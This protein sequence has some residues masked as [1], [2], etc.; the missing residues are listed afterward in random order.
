MP[1]NGTAPPESPAPSSPPIASSSTSA[2]PTARRASSA[3]CPQASSSSAQPGELESTV[4]DSTFGDGYD[5][6]AILPPGLSPGA[7]Q[8]DVSVRYSTNGGGAEAAASIV[9]EPGVIGLMVAGV[10]FV[11]RRRRRRSKR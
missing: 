8:A 3:T 10:G 1:G 6:G 5:L 2:S 9:P 4:F 11:A 7:V